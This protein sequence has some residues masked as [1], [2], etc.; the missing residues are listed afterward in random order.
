MFDGGNQVME[1][2][3]RGAIIIAVIGSI[4]TD[5]IVGGKCLEKKGSN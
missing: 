5:V 4:G 1:S 3:G 2:T